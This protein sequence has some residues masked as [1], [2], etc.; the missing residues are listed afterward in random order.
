MHQ[1]RT[2]E[3]LVTGV[4]ARLMAVD[5]RTVVEACTAVLRD[6]VEYL[7]VDVCFL[8]RN[9]E[10]LDATVLVAEW[11]PRTNVPTP[12][13]LAVVFFRDAD[14]IFAAA[15]HA[16]EVK[17]VR[18]HADD[19]QRRVKDGS[20]VDQTSMAA[21]PLLSG[22]VTTGVLG[23]VKHG[24]REWLV[25]EINALKAIAAF[26]AQLQAR[27]AAEDRLRYLA[28]HDA[29]TGLANRRSLLSE[30]EHR[31]EPGR[32][33]PVAVL[34]LDVDRLKVVNDALGHAAGDAYLRAIG[35]RLEAAFAADLVVRMGGDEFIIVV[36]AP[37]TMDGAHQLAK[38]AQ[39]VAAE[40]V[41]LQTEEVSRS[42]SIGIAL[43]VPGRS[44][45]AELV[46]FA[47]QS[48]LAAKAQGG[49]AVVGF[50]DEMRTR[51]QERND[52]EMHLRSAIHGDELVLYYQP[53]VDLA[54]GQIIGV[55]ALVRWQHPIRGLLLPD[56]FIG[57]AESTNLAGELGRWVLWEAC[58]QMHD[59]Q[60]S[61]PELSLKLRVNISPAQLISTDFVET[62]ARVLEE[63]ELSGVD[64]CLEITEHAVIHDLDR[65][66][67][68]LRGLN[69]L[70]VHV[71]I[72][73][74][75]TGRSSLGQLKQLPVDTLKIDR[76]FV[77]NLGNSSDDLAI[78]KSIISLADSFGLDVVAEGVET[79]QAAEML[80]ELGCGN[81]QGYL[82]SKPVPPAEVLEILQRG[83]KVA[84]YPADR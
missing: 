2:L 74:F 77:H 63:Y 78:V 56:S 72:D 19:Y 24:D 3:E 17:I 54:S 84:D 31:L 64:L 22:S 75:G 20:G 79:V 33:G 10:E 80:L 57:I 39:V 61:L 71:A 42:V 48:A 7:D 32:P 21:V 18:P 29:L 55:E 12:D 41:Q 40:P 38:Q 68:T 49:N 9:D 53:E 52:I 44:S 50:T 35:G 14:P 65:V 25:S 59:W 66:L 62:V 73:D 6:L 81:A 11:P 83:G 36:R 47:D 70:G 34:F 58:R 23:F 37:T 60:E 30:L 69:E 28:E 4:A 76:G 43:G 82:F 13:P 15:K 5:S 51:A 67:V 45:V 1:R 8:R 26:L 16:T 46:G 27:I